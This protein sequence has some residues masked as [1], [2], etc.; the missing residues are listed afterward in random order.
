MKSLHFRRQC[1]WR[2]VDSIHP[3]TYR[4]SHGTHPPIY[5][6]CGRS[7]RPF[8]AINKYKLK[9]SISIRTYN[10]SDILYANKSSTPQL[11][12]DR[13]ILSFGQVTRLYE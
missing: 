9:L 8:E 10:G 7:L 13:S 1:Y 11:Q 5:Y 3:R 12:D 2:Q 6:R 4:C